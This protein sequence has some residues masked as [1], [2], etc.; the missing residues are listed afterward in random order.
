MT[1]AVPRTGSLAK[2]ERS[3][4][5]P[6]TARLE[7]ID[8]GLPTRQGS[9]VEPPR[10]GSKKVAEPAESKPALGRQGGRAGDRRVTVSLAHLRSNPSSPES[11]GHRLSSSRKGGLLKIPGESPRESRSHGGNEPEDEGELRRKS[12]AK[13]LSKDNMRLAKSQH[14]SKKFRL[15]HFEV[16]HILE[17]FDKQFDTDGALSIASFRKALMSIFETKDL[18]ERIVLSAWEGFTNT[19]DTSLEVDN[20][21]VDLFFQWYVANMF[22]DVAKLRQSKDKAESELLIYNLAKHHQVSPYIMDKVKRKF[23][24][25]DTDRS[26]NI[27]F[28]EFRCMM[29]F[30]LKDDKRNDL[31]EDRLG[32]FW[33][34]IDRDGSG[35]VDFQEFAQ[36]YLKYFNPDDE[37]SMGPIEAFYASFNPDAQRHNEIQR[38][39]G[40]Q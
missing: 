34:E 8:K 39:Q 36:W 21:D 14:L 37:E 10:Q 18:D 24:K 15:E 29:K 13:T 27:E 6:S 38:L 26:G 30:M 12:R 32:R 9:K 40:E 33:A 3:N 28:E 19:T 16:K 5:N 4:S 35:E 17:E 23:D 1:A 22:S 25:F 2:L 31:S 20:F 7:L 11:L